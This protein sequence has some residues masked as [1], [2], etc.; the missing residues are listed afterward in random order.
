VK[1]RARTYALWFL[2]LLS[3]GVVVYQVVGINASSIFFSAA[4][5]VPLVPSIYL[6]NAA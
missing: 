3:V 2:A 1:F 5:V 6:E 4:F